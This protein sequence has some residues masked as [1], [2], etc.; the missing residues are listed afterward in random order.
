YI[1][2]AELDALEPEVREYEPRIALTPGTDSLSFYRR[3]AAGLADYLAPDGSLMLEIGCTQA[4]A[5]G[6]IVR[7]AGLAKFTL[8][9]DLAG[10]PR[11]LHAELITECARQG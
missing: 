3:I 7:G 10:L 8:I 9:N 2:E 11:V 1:A 5:V 6:E 4:Q